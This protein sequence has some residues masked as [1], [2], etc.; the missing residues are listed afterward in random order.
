MKALTLWRPWPYA[1]FCPEL[2]KD[3]ENRDWHL[4]QSVVGTRVAI[5]AGLLYE[6]EADRAIYEVFGNQVDRMS[7]LNAAGCIIGTVVFLASVENSLS[8]WAALG[9][10]HWPIIEPRA[11]PE[12]I[13]CRGAQGIWNVPPEIAERIRRELTTA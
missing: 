1:I 10:K 11:L 13:P 5:H 6:R 3:V 8:L 2:G 4:W 12:P 7:P 9:K